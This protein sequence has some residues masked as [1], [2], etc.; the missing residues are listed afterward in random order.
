[1]TKNDR[2]QLQHAT[3]FL[4][5][6]K[7]RSDRLINYFLASYF[8]CGIFFAFY[9]DTWLI[10]VGVGG[11]SLLAYYG[12]KIA[13]PG[14]NL[15]QYVL[16]AVFGIFMAQY[17]YQMHGMFEMHFFCFY[18]KRNTYHLSELE[19]ADPDGFSGCYPPFSFRISTEF[20]D[21]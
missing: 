14:S 8:I 10:A 6:V 11:L 5:E 13:L 21:G 3:G 7:K 4:L 12:V 15:Y 17:I 18:R 9:Y 20:R 16:S 19:A 2:Q 1:M